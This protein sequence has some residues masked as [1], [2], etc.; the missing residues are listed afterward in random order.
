MKKVVII[1]FMGLF[2]LAT[3]PLA[4][5]QLKGNGELVK[6][7][8]T[9]E[10]FDAIKLGSAHDLV[11]IPGDVY[12][13]TVETDANLQEFVKV[14]VRNSTLQFETTKVIRKYTEMRFYVTVPTLKSLR[15]S[16]AA[17][18]KTEGTLKGNELELVVSGA[19][20]VALH[21]DYAAIMVNASGASE[22]VLA[23][24]AT[25]SNIECSGASE[26]KANSLVTT[27]SVVRASGASNCNVNA[28][29]SLA[30]DA[31]GASDVNY[32][33]NPEVVV[34][35]NGKNAT[36][37]TMVGET[38]V[39][40]NHH[41]YS[42]TTKVSL[43]NLD[44]EVVDGDTTVVALG[45]HRLVVSDD[46]NVKWERNRPR[47]FNGSWGGVDIGLNGYLTP[48]FNMD[49]AKADEYLDLQMEK[50]INVNLNLYEQNI[51]LCRKSDNLGLVTGLGL[52]WNNYRF[53][54]P[55]YLSPDSSDIKGF[56]MDGISVRKTKLT[57]F[58]LTIPLFFEIQTNQAL[59]RHQ[60]HFAAGAIVSARL[61]THTKVYFNESNQEFQLK[62][63]ITG[64][65]VQNMRSPSGGTRNIAKDFSSY[66]LSPFKFDLSVRFGYGIVNLYATYS[67][68]TMFKKDRG[69]ELYPF[70]A[71]ISLVGW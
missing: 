68:N 45:N 65:V 22:V 8:R 23:G 64:Q 7:D 70:S 50:S 13:V 38:R 57:S 17:E 25:V 29:S 21:L 49:L 34:V 31:S 60:F 53:N 69:P 54:H 5:A 14:E 3:S 47:K 18:V 35:R 56:Y 19:S 32:V 44:F 9:V 27:S 36:S 26:I 10:P 46:G 58:Y 48:D 15:V 11:I 4:Q 62:D 39:T 43:G 12:G 16:G 28:T 42:D 24:N 2:T 52:S 55:T 20:E 33:K 37:I 71:G 30:Y 6:Q 61:S 67:L 41:N 51:S 66:Q 63:P 1:I 40:T 59:R